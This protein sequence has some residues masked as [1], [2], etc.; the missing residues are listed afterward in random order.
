MFY[1]YV[2]LDPRRSGKYTYKNVS[3]LFEPFYIGKGKNKRYLDHITQVDRK[4]KS[5]FREKLLKILSE[6]SKQELQKYILILRDGLS[7]EEAFELEKELIKSIGRA[8]LG[9]GC[10]TNHTDG[11]EGTRGGRGSKG[12]RW[13]QSEDAKQKISIANKGKPKT[14][15]HKRKL[16]IFHT[17][18]KHTEESLAKMSEIKKGERNSMFGKHRTLKDKNK[19]SKTLKGKYLGEKASHHKLTQQD[20]VQIKIELSGSIKQI[21]IAEKFKVHP[22]V[23]S[24]IST[25]K[26]WSNF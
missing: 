4:K 18:R 3:F 16:S 15:A 24:K 26:S 19:I 25:G 8:D 2:Y 9:L 5:Y 1:V 12:A 10:L 6:Y 14:E 23:I 17:G 13:T 20:I 22:S 21:K 11:G 7:E